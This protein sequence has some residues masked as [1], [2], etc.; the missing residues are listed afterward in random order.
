MFSPVQTQL[1]STTVEAPIMP[2]FESS[3]SI[4]IPEYTIEPQAELS[5]LA[6]KYKVNESLIYD[7]AACES[8]WNINAINVNTNG[9][10]DYGLLQINDTHK[11]DA[12]N[13]GFDITKYPDNLEYGIILFKENGTNPWR[14]SKQCWS[15]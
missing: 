2:E 11:L 13:R 9:T 8:G 4:P 1:L 6:Y 14:A 3:I 12:K 7:I 5:L 15:H 10:K